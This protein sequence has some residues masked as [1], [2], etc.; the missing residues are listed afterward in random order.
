MPL[1]DVIARFR[2]NPGPTLRA[3]IRRPKVAWQYIVRNSSNKWLRGLFGDKRTFDLLA[4][5][6]DQSGLLESLKKRLQEKFANLEGRTARGNVY[7][8]GALPLRQARF[9]YALA[10]HFQFEKMVETGVC[11]GFAT[12]VIL[13]AIAQNG[14]GGLY[15]IDYPEFTGDRSASSEFWSGK[16]G[17]V[18]PAECESGWL[19]PG[20]LR[21]RWALRLGKS[22]DLL[23]PWL[24]E[25]GSIDCFFHDSEHSYANQLAEFRSAYRYLRKGGVIVASDA[26]WSDAFVD[27]V[28]E[29]RD[30]SRVYW[31]D[32]SLAVLAK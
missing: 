23:E 22:S 30:E 20:D 3:A 6:L 21:G 15:S 9:L 31:V 27:F 29:L 7:S 4:S 12:T 24:K 32:H 28:K 10:R 17:A 2:R 1:F 5:E 26:N 14:S 25:L 13:E 11:N 8:P 19:V 16:G 18:V